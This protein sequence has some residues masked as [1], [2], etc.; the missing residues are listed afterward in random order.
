MSFPCRRCPRTYLM[1]AT[2]PCPLHG[3]QNRT[4]SIHS[5]NQNQLSLVFVWQALPARS[6]SS[7]NLPVAL[8][9]AT[10]EVYAGLGD[11]ASGDDAPIHLFPEGGMVRRD[12][13]QACCQAIPTSRRPPTSSRATTKA[14]FSF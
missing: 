10:A 6:Y 8:R 3:S 2:P 1:L 9:P 4:E 14:A 13:A 5:I 11:P 7:I 12:T